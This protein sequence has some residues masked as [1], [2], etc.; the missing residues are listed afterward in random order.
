M[1]TQVYTVFDSKAERFLR[2]FFAENTA[3]A[4]RSFQELIRTHDHQ[5]NKF[6]EDY[7]LFH[8]GSYDEKTGELTPLPAP[9][10]LGLAIQFMTP[11]L[12]A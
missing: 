7:A 1:E 2:P 6:P 10:N 11:A 8:I 3:V 4:L 12:E 9:V 5:F